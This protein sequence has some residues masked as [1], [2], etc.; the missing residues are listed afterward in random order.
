VA[1]DTTGIGATATAVVNPATGVMTGIRITN[2]GTDYTEPPIVTLDRGEGT[3][4]ALGTVTIGA[5][6]YTG[7]L[8]KK[9]AGTLTLTGAN[10]YSGDTIVNEGTLSLAAAYLADM[11]DVKLA[12]TGAVLNLNTGATDTIHAFVIGGVAQAIGE[13]GALGSGA[14]HESRAH[15]RFRQAPRH[16]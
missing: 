2:P 6:T 4:A 9:G 8:T 15:H 12:A 1:P 5:N 10:T 14:T 11:A 7:G 3:A 13:W 16:L